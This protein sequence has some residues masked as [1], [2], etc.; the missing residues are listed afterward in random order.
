MAESSRLS[1]SS[2]KIEAELSNDKLKLGED[3]H[4]PDFD[5]DLVHPLGKFN[6]SFL[7]F[8]GLYVEKEAIDFCRKLIGNK[9]GPFLAPTDL[10][11]NTTMTESLPNA[12]ENLTKGSNGSSQIPAL[13]IQG[14]QN[15]DK[16][17]G[18]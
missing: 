10:P 13:F 9:R 5:S 1:L 8:K 7:L 15:F 18:K 14:V 3:F 17:D 11:V 6:Q 16:F 12:L 2:S 4:N